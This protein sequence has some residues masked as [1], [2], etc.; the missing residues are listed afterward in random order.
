VLD[1]DDGTNTGGA[2]AGRCS[3]EDFY[4]EELMQ[5]VGL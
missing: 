3:K 4:K 1:I 5:L 2:I